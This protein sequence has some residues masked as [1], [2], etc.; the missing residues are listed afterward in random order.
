MY[1]ADF[2][3]RIIGHYEVPLDHPGRDRTS[4]RIWR[5]AFA[6][7][8]SSERGSP[9]A[10]DLRAATAEELVGHFS[11]PNLI[12]RMRALDELTDRIDPDLATA[13]VREALAA[14]PAENRR[15]PD[16]AA[17]LVHALYRLDL[18][19]KP[20]AMIAEQGLPRLQVL[21]ELAEARA[22]A[23]GVDERAL[24]LSCLANP[25]PFVCRAAVDALGQ[26][27]SVVQIDPLLARMEA[28]A[29]SDA[30]LRHAIR[31]ALRNQLETP[32]AME[33]ASGSPAARAPTSSSSTS[34]WRSTGKRSAA[35]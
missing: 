26:H 21:R 28:T 33:Y 15:D 10:P 27:P 1:V 25:D 12:T 23:I 20:G 32:G 30:I 19:E 14:G 18:G 29:E 34:A 3:N 17:M 13:A 7:K 24:M 9:R 6:G 11:S 35:S 2:Y 31:I 8:S 5:I 22:D 4:G 16:R